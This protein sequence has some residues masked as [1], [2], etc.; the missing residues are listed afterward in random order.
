MVGAVIVAAGESRRMGGIDKVFVPLR[1]RPLVAH[2][3]RAFNESP[4]VDRIVLVVG[5]ARVEEARRLVQSGNFRKAGVCAGGARRQDSVRNGLEALAACDYVL[6]H[7]G[8]RP[9]VTPSLIKDGLEAARETGAAIAA[10]PVKDTVKVVSDGVVQSTL[11]RSA[12]WAIQTPQVFSYELALRAHR[13]CKEDVTDDAAMVERLGVPVR[14][15]IGSYENLK[16]T[17]PDDLLLAEAVLAGR[18]GGAR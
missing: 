7:D 1:G 4:L 2:S 13:L 17:T 15:Y 6:I 12:L 14:V 5:A 10:V 8:A 18:E 11:D 16:V 3:L 9:C